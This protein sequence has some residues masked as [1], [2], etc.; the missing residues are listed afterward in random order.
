MRIFDH[1]SLSVCVIKHSERKMGKIWF[2]F[3][4]TAFPNLNIYWMRWQSF[5][6]IGLEVLTK[7]QP[8][9]YGVCSLVFHSFDTSHAFLS[10][11]PLHLASGFLTFSEGMNCV[12]WVLIKSGEKLYQFMRIQY[13][14]SINFYCIKMGFERQRQMACHIT[15]MLPRRC[16]KKC[17]N[18]SRYFTS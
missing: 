17:A 15:N 3:S 9:P 1:R 11:H 2:S 5:I 4:A 13:G 6:R 10:E 14:A 16:I 18:S 12:G 7:L 8:L